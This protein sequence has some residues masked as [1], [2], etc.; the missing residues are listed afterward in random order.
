M[1]KGYTLIELITALALCSL[2]AV[3]MISL[4]LRYNSNYKH[5]SKR[6]QNH[7]YAEEALLFIDNTI[8][9]SKQINVTAS[10]IELYYE[11]SS[12]KKVIGQNSQ[13]DIVITHVENGVSSTTNN[14][15]N[16]ISNFTINKK[17][18]TIYI[19]ITVNTGERFSRCIGIKLIS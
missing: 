14:V 11:D 8:K 15:L 1:K 12:I 13:G 9:T 16:N 5:E 10:Y 4:L 19:S 7:F 17:E 2:A 6:I 3:S 18:N